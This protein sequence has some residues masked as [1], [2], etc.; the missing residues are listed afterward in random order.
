[1]KGYIFGLGVIGSMGI[2]FISLGLFN[3]GNVLL[4]IAP[5]SYMGWPITHILGGLGIIMVCIEGWLYK[6]KNEQHR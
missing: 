1:M 5:D 2:I 6:V 3:R 4:G